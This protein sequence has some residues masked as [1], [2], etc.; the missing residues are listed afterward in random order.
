MQVLALS[1]APVFVILFY[2][3]F[4]DKYEREPL[5]MLIPALIAGVVIT[6]PVLFIGQF[7]E[8]IKPALSTSG[9]AFYISFLEAGFLEEG[10]KFLALYLLVWRHP[11]FNEKFD[12]IVYAVFISLGFAMIENIIYVAEGGFKI[13]MLRAFTAVPAHALFGIRMGFYFGIAHVYKELRTSYLIRAL[14]IPAILH[15]IYN[16]MLLS[17]LYLLLLAFIPY[18]V[19]MLISGFREM[20]VISDTSEFRSEREEINSSDNIRKTEF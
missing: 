8:F 15:G 14:M 16:F 7:L 18:L 6:V 11:D 13:A 20:K 2:V 1:L 3:Y 17:E 10:F 5:K 4:R 9:N 19:W 12:G